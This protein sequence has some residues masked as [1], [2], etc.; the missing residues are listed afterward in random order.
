MKTR[1]LLSLSLLAALALGACGLKSQNQ[2]ADVATLVA[3]SLTETALVP[4]PTWTAVPPTPA[5]AQAS[6]IT[7]RVGLIS[8]PTPA[9]VVY[10]VDKSSGA[11]AYAE[12][13]AN[14]SDMA[15][16]SLVVEPGT[17]QV[18]AFSKD[19]NGSAAYSM[20]GKGMTPV[21]VA[22]NQTVSNIVVQF[23]GQGDCGLVFAIPDAPDGRFKG[24]PGPSADCLAGGQKPTAIK[25]LVYKP[26]STAECQDIQEQAEDAL[27]ML[28]IIQMGTDFRAP[29]TL[30]A[31]TGCTMT[32]SATGKQISDPYKV[33]DALTKRFSD[34]TNDGNFD[35]GGPTGAATGLRRGSAVMLIT[36]GWKP[37]PEVNCPNDKPIETCDL[38][39][40]QMLYLVTIQAAQ[41]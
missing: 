39:P 8:P 28:F 20:D 23:P 2:E 18:Y 1:L 10:A 30:D 33:L 35:A 6:G 11:W 38:T 34:W 17:Y 16:F 32:A 25:N 29:G 4:L 27:K 7:G 19:G 24:S 26:L 5:P 41:K 12:T 3:Q 31:G 36:A 15:P 13:A 22:A 21:T 9:M 14:E 40:E 37:A